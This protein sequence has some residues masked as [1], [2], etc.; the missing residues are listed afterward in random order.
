MNGILRSVINVSALVLLPLLAVGVTAAMV[1]LAPE[2][3]SKTGGPPAQTV[4]VVPV[5]L[6]SS[7]AR[8]FAT[9][10]VEA[11]RQVALTPEVSGRVVWTDPRLI[12]G[13]RFSEGDTL[14]RLDSRDFQAALAADEARLAQVDL[15]LALERQRQ[16][17]ARRE[18]D[19]VGSGDKAEEPLALRRPHLAVAEANHKS[20][21]SAVDRAKLNVSRTSLRVPF[22]AVVVSESAEEGQVLNAATPVA[23]L[24]GTDAVRVII[25]VPVEDLQKVYI[26]PDIQSQGSPVIV[27]RGTDLERTGWVVGLSGQLDPQ[28]RT[29]QVVA[30]IPDPMSGERPL[31]PG[32][33][34]DVVIDGS[35]LDGVAAVPRVALVGDNQVW[36]AQDG[37]L[38]RRDVQIGWRDVSQVYVTSGLVEGDRVVVTPLGIP[39]E[40]MPINPVERTGGAP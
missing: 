38:S 40:G 17:T 3:E 28:T 1:L 21:L 35:A 30:W 9:G 11:A 6:V 18:W 27:R 37:K 14:L 12:P 8:V 36:V 20:A 10:L 25:A 5:S 24:V 23:T 29:A 7:P 33:F 26:P 13:G 2:A 39:L 32:S 31:L 19:L 4:E 16:L 34:V 22:N 15:E